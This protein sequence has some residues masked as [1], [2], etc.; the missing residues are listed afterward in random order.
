MKIT[1]ITATWLHVPIPEERR[2]KSDYGVT[3][4]FDTTLV[5]VE[6]DAGI[7]G[8]GEARGALPAQCNCAGVCAVIENEFAPLLIGEDARDISRLWEIMY[9][10]V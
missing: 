3:D 1:S 5:R 2:H 4:S 6:T 10:V 9:E 7:V 8:W